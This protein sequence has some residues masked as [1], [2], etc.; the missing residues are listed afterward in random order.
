MAK[1]L[2]T[3][4]THPAPT[5]DVN[6]DPP[7]GAAIYLVLS[8]TGSDYGDPAK[9]SELKQRLTA[10]MRY[11]ASRGKDMLPVV[12]NVDDV[13]KIVK[14]RFLVKR[15]STVHTVNMHAKLV[16]VD[17]SLLYVGSDNQYPH[18]NEEFGC[19]VEDEEHIDSFFKE[20]YDGIWTRSIT[21]GD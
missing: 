9:I 16:C 17:R 15:I 6:K 12:T 3:F 14:E 7:T 2:S 21:T 19:W 5:G 10:I 1:A 18:Y 13:E 4:A 11:M 8:S 20:F